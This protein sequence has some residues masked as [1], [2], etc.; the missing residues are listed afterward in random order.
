[1]NIL[2]LS[3]KDERH[4]LAGGAECV[5]EEI[6]KRLTRRGHAVT[7]ISSQYR[8][9]AHEEERE[10]VRHIRVGSRWTVYMKA[11]RYMRNHLCKWPDVVID[12]MNTMP[13][14]AK[15]A[16]NKPTILLVHQ[17]CRRVWFYEMAFPLSLVGYLLEPIV[18]RLLRN[19]PVLTV[20]KSTREDLV[21]YG[22]QRSKISIIRE[23]LV[24]RPKPTLGNEEKRSEPTILALGSIRAMKRTRHIVEAFE[25]AKKSIPNL[26]L[27][28]AGKPLGRYGARTL[29]RIEQSPWKQHITVK[30]Q[31]S[32]E[33]KITLLRQAH[34][35]AVT[36]VK[37]G[38]GLV[39]S[40]ANSQGTPAVVYDADGLRDSVKHNRTGLVCRSN[41]PA[42]LAENIVALLGNTRKYALLQRNAWKS[43]MAMD[44]DHSTDDMESAIERLRHHE[45]QTPTRP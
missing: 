29:A 34:V 38:W 36:S 27:I 25:L 40:E 8:G 14:F 42:A 37:E 39:V 17:L 12:E 10:G 22:F 3:W 30:G 44:F 7:I 35:L 4:P 33:E 9:A 18:L 32:P 24:I 31:V 41:T 13:F 15:F 16:T 1:M 2:W 26:R 5:G 21:R 20:S 43:A 19:Q 6:R 45:E 11:V 28:V 23:G